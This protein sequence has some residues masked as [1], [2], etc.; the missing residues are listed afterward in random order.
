MRTAR[1]GCDEVD[2]SCAGIAR[3]DGRKRPYAPRIHQKRRVHSTRWI[4]GSSPAMTIV[5]YA[6]AH[7]ALGVVNTPVRKSGY[8]GVQPR[9]NKLKQEPDQ[10]CTATWR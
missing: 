7:P 1:A 4:A 8:P 3:E 6:Q 10:Y 2:S 9:P 5:A